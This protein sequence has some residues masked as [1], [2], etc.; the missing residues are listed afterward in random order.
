MRKNCFSTKKLPPPHGNHF[1]IFPKIKLF[2]LNV[3]N[4]IKLEIKWERIIFLKMLEIA[5]NTK[6]TWN[7]KNK[8]NKFLFFNISKI[9]T[10]FKHPINFEKIQQCV[11]ESL[12][13]NQTD[14]RTDRGRFNISRPG[15]MARRE[16]INT[17]TIVYTKSIHRWIIIQRKENSTMFWIFIKWNF[18][19]S[20]CVHQTCHEGTTGLQECASPLFLCTQASSWIMYVCMI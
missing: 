10:K 16:I 2:F 20:N 12:C 17:C 6:K 3:G 1:S 4:S 19:S 14:R 13:E 11:F 5:H 8:S 15:P 7:E 18:C 9:H